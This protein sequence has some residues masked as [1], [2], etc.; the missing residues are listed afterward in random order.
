[1]FD[2]M[3]I[4]FLDYNLVQISSE[5][6]LGSLVEWK[7]QGKIILVDNINFSYLGDLVLENDA[8]KQKYTLNGAFGSVYERIRKSDCHGKFVGYLFR[9]NDRYHIIS[10]MNVTDELLYLLE[11]HPITDETEIVRVIMVRDEVGGYSKNQG[12]RNI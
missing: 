12:I 6:L 8:S 4:S 3:L 1:M 2:G 10:I 9:D 5:Q 7:N 11:P